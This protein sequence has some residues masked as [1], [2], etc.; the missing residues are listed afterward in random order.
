MNKCQISQ[1]YD[2]INVG[3]KVVAYIRVS[4]FVR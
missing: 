1:K 2:V 3:N 4:I